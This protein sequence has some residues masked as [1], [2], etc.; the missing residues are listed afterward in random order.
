MYHQIQK[1][2]TFTP[3]TE[4]EPMWHHPHLAPMKVCEEKF[5]NLRVFQFTV[6]NFSEQIVALY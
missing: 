5:P 6:T 1:K 4:P 2:N 3:S